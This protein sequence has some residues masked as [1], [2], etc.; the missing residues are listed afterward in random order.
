MAPF[1]YIDGNQP[2]CSLAQFGLIPFWTED[3]RFGRR[4]YNARSETVADK[5]SYRHVWKECKFGLAVMESFFEPVWENG[6]SKRWNIRRADL[7]PIAVPCIWQRLTD[8]KTE[9]VTLSFSIL[10]INADKNPMMMQFHKHETEKRSIV[11]L[12]E[13]EYMLCL[14][15]N[16]TE[17][18]KLLK[19]A[20]DDFL[21]AESSP[22]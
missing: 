18:K 9:E 3:T 1:I 21:I 12:N 22:R 2:K 10:T 14:H 8:Q 17:A 7:Q 5:L 20:S 15:A 6:I 16:H 13:S 19:P 11:V 4:T